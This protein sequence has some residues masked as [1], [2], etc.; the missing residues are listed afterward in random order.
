M[1][2]ISIILIIVVGIFITI[3]SITGLETDRFNEIISQKIVENNN[4]V[5]VKLQKIKFKIDIKKL[6]LFVET[7]G[8]TVIYKNIEIP[9]KNI[10]AYLDLASFFSSKVNV[11][12]IVILSNELNIQKLKRILIKVKPSNLNSLIVN[13]VNKGKLFTEI[14]LY[15][16]K[17]QEISNI[18]TR[19]KV[20]EL[21]I[22]LHDE[23][24]FKNSNFDFFADNT[25]ILIKNINGNSDGIFVENGNLQ[26]N[27]GNEINI[28][29]DFDTKLSLS[30]KNISN[31]LL[32]LNIKEIL[33]KKIIINAN[34][35]HFF[36]LSLD[37]TFKLKK[38]DYKNK[39]EANQ[40]FFI[41]NNS[42]K[43]IILE[44][45]INQ[46]YFKNITFDTNLNSKDQNELLVNGLYSFENNEF[47]NF[48]II[49]KFSKKIHNII[50]NVDFNPSLNFEFLNYK[51]KK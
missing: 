48:D 39:G 10:K 30:E 40:L 5:S 47:K 49:N 25:D 43:N 9:I 26:I 6:S 37:K 44:K 14:E 33:Q 17:K 41:L 11:N 36:D 46:L 23:L 4:K 34:I 18:I 21:E 15:L 42:I 35:K 51:K 31:Y 13:K 12:K 24:K 20:R 38:Y 16:N 32:Y 28:K 50:L 29:S 1:K 22:V 7:N 2:K 19:G 8:P 45:D 27:K 3:L